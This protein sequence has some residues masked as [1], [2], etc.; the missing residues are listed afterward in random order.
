M[1]RRRKYDP[2][3]EQTEL[4]ERR[5]GRP[6]S[7]GIKLVIGNIDTGTDNTRR[8]RSI[9]TTKAENELL[10]A[11]FERIKAGRVNVLLSTIVDDY[12]ARTDDVRIID[13]RCKITDK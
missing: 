12:I 3:F 8:G 7:A 13:N 1:G 2:N 4:F 5:V 10:K 11:I 6:H 9:W